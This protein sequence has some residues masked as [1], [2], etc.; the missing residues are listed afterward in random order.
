MTSSELI[1]MGLLAW[2]ILSTAGIFFFALKSKKHT[3]RIRLLTWGP[4]IA[5]IIGHICTFTLGHKL[6]EAMIIP[7][8]LV[9][10][11]S[12]ILSIIYYPVLSGFLLY[13]QGRSKSCG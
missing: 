9:T 4:L 1:F 10:V 6:L 2:P 7:I 13:R 12:V 11:W 5:L 3:Q 8:L